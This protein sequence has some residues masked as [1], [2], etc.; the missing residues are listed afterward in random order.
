[1]AAASGNNPVCKWWAG[2]A[3]L[4]ISFNLPLRKS[5]Y[6]HINLRSQ[7]HTPLPSLP[8]LHP[9]C[10]GIPLRVVLSS[11]WGEGV[12]S[13][14]PACAPVLMASCRTDA[15]PGWRCLIAPL[16]IQPLIYAHRS[17]AESWW[18]VQPLRFWLIGAV[19][20]ASKQGAG[21]WS[22]AGVFQ[23]FSLCE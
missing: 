14:A 11:M 13:C 3:S 7:P 20:A 2:V 12:I 21:W 8:P 1:M 23:I 6:R 19:R 4:P 15:W 5:A 10:S 9:D 18:S 16:H 22:R 17:Y